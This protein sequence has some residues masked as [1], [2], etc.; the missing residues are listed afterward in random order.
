MDAVQLATAE[1]W[2]GERIYWD[3]AS[4]ADRQL[5]LCRY[6]FA[7][8]LFQP[9]WG[10]LD[11]ACGS[12]YGAAFLADKVRSVCGVDV[13]ENAID[14]AKS[15]YHNGNLKYRRADLQ[16]QLPFP[17]GAFDAITSF[18]TLE[19]V[20]N[21]DFMLSEFHRVLKNDGILV[22]SSPDRTVSERI[23]LDNRF[24]V[25]ERS[26][27]EFV[28]LLGRRSFTVQQVLGHG[29][30]NPVAAHWKAVHRLFKAGSSLAGPKIRSRLELALARPFRRLRARFY[31]IS[32]SSMKLT[33]LDTA[34]F[35]YVVVVAQKRADA[36]EL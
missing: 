2:K 22:I 27:R 25:S 8:D 20:E 21:Q 3:I 15:R 9:E 24:H 13:N 17:D 14:Y 1:A 26:K 29:D 6:E 4:D 5:H 33:D 31:E 18:E 32:G 12:G 35:L 23:G 28:E 11:A 30:G 7:R 16:S 10:C 34:I 36:S 19:H